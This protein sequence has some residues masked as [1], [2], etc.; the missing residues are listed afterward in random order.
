M[1]DRPLSARVRA[2]TRAEHDAAQG[3][4]FLDALAA[5]RLPLDAFAD[6]AVQHWFVYETL[7][8]AGQ[9]MAKDPVA[10]QF[11]LPELDRVP[12]LAA[13]LAYLLGPQWRERIVPLPATTAYRDRLGA[14]AFRRP[15]AFV[16]H[17]YTRY[18][19][20]LSGGQFLGPAIAEA[21]GLNGE[22]HRFFT[23]DGV[24]PPA[25]RTRYRRL[26]DDAE[27]PPGEEAAFLAEVTEAYRLNIAML[28]DLRERWTR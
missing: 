22:G 20:D 26:L 27:W 7:E 19:G 9:K 15:A 3:S 23:F 24:D 13:D 25:F 16:A 18:L 14:V 8:D 5:G 11:V 28:A 10:G 17:H 4:G 1:A 2:G 12:A 21:Y 6:L